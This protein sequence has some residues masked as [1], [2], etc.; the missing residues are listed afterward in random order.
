M[1]KWCYS[2]RKKRTP[3]LFHNC[4][5]YLFS[6]FK[7]TIDLCYGI[8]AGV[9]PMQV[10]LSIK[11]KYFIVLLNWEYNEVFGLQGKGELRRLDSGYYTVTQVDC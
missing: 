11:P 9:Q 5:S 4:V 2:K 1:D 6:Y 3:R 10:Y 7:S 8:L